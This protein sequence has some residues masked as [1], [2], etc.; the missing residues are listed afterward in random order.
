MFKEEEIYLTILKN[1]KRLYMKTRHLTPNAVG[2]NS[3]L[4]LYWKKGKDAISTTYS[5][6]YTV[7]KAGPKQVDEK[8][9]QKALKVMKR[10][11]YH[12]RIHNAKNNPTSTDK[13]TR[14]QEVAYF[15]KHP[16]CKYKTLSLDPLHS[17][18][19]L[20]MMVHIYTNDYVH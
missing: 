16:P 10:Y 2:E 20:K 11:C 1:L 12:Y 17:H 14:V 6:V 18:K 19:K 3:K 5:L 8:N 4:F 9:K 15:I 13:N 7:Q